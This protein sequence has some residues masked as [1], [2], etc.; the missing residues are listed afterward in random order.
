MKKPALALLF[1]IV[2]QPFPAPAQIGKNIIDEAKQRNVFI[3][4][5]TRE[6]RTPPFRFLGKKHGQHTD[7]GVILSDDYILSACHLVLNSVTINILVG[8]SLEPLTIVKTDPQR[9]LILLRSPLKSRIPPVK[10]AEKTT[11]GDPVFIVSNP[12]GI[13]DKTTYGYLNG[14]ELGT[15]F[16]KKMRPEL[17]LLLSDA[18]C[19]SG[20]SGG[21]LWDASNA[22]LIGI[23]IGLQEFGLH[24]VIVP[25]EAIREFLRDTPLEG[26]P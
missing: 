25:A 7:S 8:I 24:S 6:N 4:V 17:T 23:V 14:E 15:F 13:L 9:D 16:D 26:L 20:S 5:E 19:I 21:G 22:T 11:G 18:F 3:V 12:L 2:L 10:M 1:S